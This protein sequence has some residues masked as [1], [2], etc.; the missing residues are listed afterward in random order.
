MKH[1]K[2]TIFSLF[3]LLA[4]SQLTA[5]KIDGI[6]AIVE[7]NIILH[8]DVEVQYQQ[9]MASG[10]YDTDL[11]C[12]ILDQLMLEKL[13]VVEAERDSIYISDDE[14]DSELER[15]I[16]Y[17][18]SLFG[19]EEKLEEYYGKSVYDLKEDF[20]ED[21]FN[22]LLAD[23]MQS[24]VFADTYVSPEEVFDFFNS[25]P[26]DSLP[27]FNTEV[28]IGEIV[29]YAKPNI[30]QKQAAK[31]KAQKIREEILAGSDFGFQALLYSDDPGSSNDGGN[32]G[33][34][35]RGQLVTEFEATAFRLEINEVSEV[36]ETQFGYHIIQLL[37]KKGNKIDVRHILITPDVGNENVVQLEKDILD[38]EEKLLSGDVTFEQA[39]ALY[40][41]E[42][43]SS[44][45]GGL[46]TNQQTGNTFFEMSELEG[47]I[48][49][50]LDGVEEGGYTPVMTHLSYDGKTG[51]RIVYLKSET[52]AHQAS[53]DTD[54]SK[55]KAV[56]KQAKQAEQ[57]NDWIEKKSPTIYVK[58]NEDYDNCTSLDKW[59]NQ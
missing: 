54:Y 30:L 21:I 32:L 58:I 9:A 44:N 3:A 50:A 29:I 24:T 49:L 55:I 7:D 53:L 16:Q 36:V 34:V 13:F 56:A 22:Q 42:E 48:A 20:R 31:E 57:M 25:I 23:R 2:Y 6:A 27:F 52:P 18:V 40:S 14:V 51:Y 35:Q 15:R 10:M 19:S 38:I 45:N 46:L 43:G 37:D 28:E 8:S 47:N 1:L 17:F 4:F 5:Q 26:Q 59:K 41:E 12:Q 39:V 11:K 33:Y